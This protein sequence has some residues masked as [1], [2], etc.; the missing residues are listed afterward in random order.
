M[1]GAIL[2][3]ITRNSIVT[4]LY[5]PLGGGTGGTGS[6]ISVS[7]I[8]C[9]TLNVASNAT[10][11]GDLSLSNGDIN[12]NGDINTGGIFVNADLAANGGTLLQ[13]TQEADILTATT[14]VNIGPA[15]GDGSQTLFG[16]AVITSNAL[17]L[18]TLN[19]NPTTVLLGSV[20]FSQGTNISNV[21]C[22]YITGD[23]TNGSIAM[24][25]STVN[26]AVSSFTVNGAPVGGGA[27]GPTGPTG[28]T[29]ATGATG[30]TGDTGPTGATGATGP[31]GPQGDTG[32][33]GATGPAG[34]GSDLSYYV[35]IPFN[36]TVTFSNDYTNVLGIPLTFAWTAPYTS[37][38]DLWE[39]N[40]DFQG[41]FNGAGDNL[42]YYL[43]FQ[44]TPAFP[45]PNFSLGTVYTDANPALAV[46]RSMS[47]GGSVGTINIVSGNITDTYTVALSNGDT[48]VFEAF[49]ATP[50]S[51]STVQFLN[52]NNRFSIRP[53]QLNF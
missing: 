34:S 52:G 40:W 29:G 45:G 47:L 26:M 44:K 12:L 9:V 3:S 21:N 19:D 2:P 28:P 51:G 20:A 30:P 15:V 42:A 11:G 7:T 37:S 6:T 25:G 33:T 32:A 46:N 5:E 49:M 14:G 23:S 41:I 1:S 16:G 10:V 13:M 4:T 50:S 39:I 18:T 48:L 22:P 27:T 35:N 17:T 8:N 38:N 24:Y 36:T 31:T 53:A 43:A